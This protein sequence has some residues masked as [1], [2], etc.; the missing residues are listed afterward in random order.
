L[1]RL[2]RNCATSQ[3]KR[4]SQA[5]LK[6]EKE[7]EK[8]AKAASPKSKAQEK[9]KGGEEAPLQWETSGDN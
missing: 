2:D 3:D 4:K 6:Q 8:K 1:A 9:K 5:D 7:K